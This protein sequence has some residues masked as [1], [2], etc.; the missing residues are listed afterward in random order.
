MPRGI[1]GSS[2]TSQRRTREARCCFAQTSPLLRDPGQLPTLRAQ[3]FIP[4]APV[5]HKG[6][7][8]LAA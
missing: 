4:R 2:D 3:L 8:G 1:V 7:L 6:L 5:A